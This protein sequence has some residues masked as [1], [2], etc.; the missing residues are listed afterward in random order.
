MEA[1]QM[2]TIPKGTDLHGFLDPHDQVAISFWIVSIAMVASTVFFLMESMSINNNWK[3][4]MNVGALVTL[5][6]AVHY[7]YMREYWV[8][9]HMSPIVYRYIDWSLT[10]PLQMIEFYLILQAVTPQLGSGM[11][12]RLLIGTVLML[13]FGYLGEAQVIDPWLGFAV[14]M[15]GWVFILYEVFLGEGGKA[16]TN[17]A[18]SSAAVKSAFSTMRFIV[19]AG[20]CIYPAGYFFGYLLGAVSSAP[21]NLLYNL[22]DFVNKIWFCLAIWGAAKGETLEANKAPAKGSLL[23]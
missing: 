20:W 21:L 10:V 22:A 2:P 9:I 23:A 12:Y 8:I 4:S 11:F 1:I 16:A 14:G 17:L 3:T 5:I 6:A 13:L 18:G 7:F 19:S 15:T